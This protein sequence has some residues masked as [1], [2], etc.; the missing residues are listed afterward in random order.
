VNIEV[1]LTLEDLESLGVGVSVVKSIRGGFLRLV[2]DLDIERDK[3]E[4]LADEK[5]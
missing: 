2:P 5:A 4:G 3:L 1:T